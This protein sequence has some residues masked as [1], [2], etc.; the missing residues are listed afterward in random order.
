MTRKLRR[1]ILALRRQGNARF[2]LTL[3]GLIYAF[4]F[5]FLLTVFLAVYLAADDAGVSGYLNSDGNGPKREGL[6][7]D[8]V[9]KVLIAPFLETVFCQWLPT[10]IVF[11]FFKRNLLAAVLLSATLFGLGHTYNLFYIIATFAIGVVLAVGFIARYT[12]GGHPILLVS[13]VHALKNLVAVT[14]HYLP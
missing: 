1:C 13:L 5:L 11:K 10:L 6:F 3:F 4:P 2:V 9:R 8:I 14:V 7:K 12:K